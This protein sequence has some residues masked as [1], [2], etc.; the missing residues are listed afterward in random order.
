MLKI[1]LK[2]LMSY[3]AKFVHDKIHKL[4]YKMFLQSFLEMNVILLSFQIKWQVV[5][6]LCST[7]IY[8]SFSTFGSN[9][10]HPQVRTYRP[11]SL[12]PIFSEIFEKQL[13]D[14]MYYHLSYHKLLTPN[15]SGFRPGDSTINQLLSIPHKI[16][17]EFDD[18]PSMKTRAVFLDLSKAFDRVWHRGIIHK[19]RHSGISGNML[20]LLNNFLT[21][22]KQ[23]VLLNWKPQS[24]TTFFGC[25]SGK[26]SFN[27]EKPEEVIFSTKRRKP[28]HPPLSMDNIEISH[29]NEHKHL[30]MTLDSQLNFQSHTRA[31]IL[32][33]RRGIGLI[34][35]LSRYVSRDILNLVYQL[36]VRPHLHYGDII[37]TQY[38]VAH[39]VTGA[40]RGT[41]RQRLYNELGWESL[42]IRRWYHRLCHFFNLKDR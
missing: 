36:Y 9:F 31:A 30:G 33:A 26:W 37:Q 15:Q 32:K 5:K 19:L 8:P 6:D 24:G 25:G 28:F 21:G 29:V 22:R 35:Y 2:R 39:V 41:N 12:L 14:V 27:V 38:A 4:V 10:R 13:F 18:I 34:R 1:N 20:A 42:C 23:K 7:I 40:W 17:C 3:S 16:Y 11:I